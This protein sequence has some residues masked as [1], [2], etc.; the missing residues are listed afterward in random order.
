MPPTPCRVCPLPHM[1]PYHTRP[2][3]T[4]APPLH[5]QNS[6]H[7]LVKTLLLLRTVIIVI[8][9]RERSCGKVMYYTCVSFCS[10]EEGISPPEWDP[11]D[12]DPP[13]PTCSGGYQSG[14]YA[15][16]FSLA[17]NTAQ[18]RFVDFPSTYLNEDSSLPWC[19]LTDSAVDTLPAFPSIVCNA[20]ITPWSTLPV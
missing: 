9:A 3:A 10:Q 14:R 19:S 8:T 1:P 6:W 20:V 16:L 18:W 4:H 7:T 11:L 13:G 17:W 12:R 2:P 15:Y 5:G